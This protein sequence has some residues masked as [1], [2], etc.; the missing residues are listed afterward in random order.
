MTWPERL[1]ALYRG[2]NFLRPSSYLELADHIEWL[3]AEVERLKARPTPEQTEEH[4]A[5]VA[6]WHVNHG[7]CTE[8]YDLKAKP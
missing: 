5:C 7:C 3:H 2:N 4:D 6:A 8:P 1:R